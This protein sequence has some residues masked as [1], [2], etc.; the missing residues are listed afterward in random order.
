[1]FISAMPMAVFVG[2]RKEGGLC[3]SAANACR[4]KCAAFRVSSASCMF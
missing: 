4:D 2:A 3:P 1:M